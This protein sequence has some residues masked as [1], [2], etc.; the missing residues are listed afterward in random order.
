MSIDPKL[1]PWCQVCGWRKG[2]VDS[3]DGVKC[4][5]GHSEP[6][7]RRVP[8]TEDEV[9]DEALEQCI[10]DWNRDREEVGR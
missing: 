6:P 7:L 2:G 4:K 10:R 3:W 8:T 5:C 9:A 1:R